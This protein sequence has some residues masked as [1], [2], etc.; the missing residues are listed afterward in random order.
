[1]KLKSD[2]PLLNFDFNLNL[3]R[4]TMAGLLTAADLTNKVGRCRLKHVDT[5]VESAWFQILKL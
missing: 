1:L 5:R 4:Y 2:A 3:R